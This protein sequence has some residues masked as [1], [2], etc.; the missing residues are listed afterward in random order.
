[1]A[2]DLGKKWKS[3]TGENA[4]TLRD[5]P[6]GNFDLSLMGDG[7]DVRD[8]THDEPNGT[9]R[10]ISGI[11]EK[12]NISEAPHARFLVI[13]DQM[14]PI[15]VHYRGIAIFNPATGQINKIVGRK[16]F[17]ASLL[18]DRSKAKFVADLADQVGF[19]GQVEGTWVATQP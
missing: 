6:L 18:A 3:Q 2:H 16:R 8:C 14:T 17:L 10:P 11:T 13:I 19:A 12:L 4:N 5:D 9:R 15:E 1:M 7:G